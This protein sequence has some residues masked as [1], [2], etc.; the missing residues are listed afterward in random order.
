MF[1]ERYQCVGRGEKC[2]RSAFSQLYLA[3]WLR[4][5]VHSRAWSCCRLFDGESSSWGGH[6]GILHVCKQDTHYHMGK[7][8]ADNSGFSFIF[9]PSRFNA[10]ETAQASSW[11]VQ[12]LWWYIEG[13]G[14]GCFARG[15]CMKKA[16]LQ[17]WCVDWLCSA[18]ISE[19]VAAYLS[20]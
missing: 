16:A 13:S 20:W 12:R 1:N 10:E 8:T 19:T 6:G 14:R 15:T 2:F 17:M 18:G 7:I 4:A 11:E 3:V 5:S 9:L